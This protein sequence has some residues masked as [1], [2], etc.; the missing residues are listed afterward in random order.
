MKEELIKLQ[1]EIE[2][3]ISSAGS[4]ADIEAIDVK[5]FSRKGPLNAIIKQI[6]DLPD[7][8]KREFGP[9]VNAIKASLQATLDEAKKMFVPLKS[10]GDPTI[11]GKEFRV[12]HLNPITLMERE[13]VN[14]FASLGFSVF[15]GPELDSDYYNFE[16]LNIPADHPARD[17]Q[18]TFYVEQEDGSLDVLMRTQTSNLQVRAMRKFGAPLRVVMPGRVFR[19]EA[20]DARHEHT[21]YQFEG[22]MV[23]PGINFS[24]L[25]SI[26]E[27]V[28]KKLYGPETKIRMRPKFYPFVEPGSN[29]EYTCFLCSG[30]GCRVCKNTGWLEIVGCG[31]IHPKVLEA[32][33]ID[34]KK[35][36]GF[37]FGFGLSRLAMLK[38][39]IDEVRLMTG[40]DLR[41]LE[42]F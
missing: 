8:K 27:V 30:K 14:I 28:G 5:Y 16:S 11:P 35:Y 18:D 29:G 39:N 3:S 31:L 17:M 37:A 23:A 24:H 42:Q 38:Y 33:G 4:L 32:G 34:P 6:K 20:T 9:F 41:F 36:S 25:K 12:G 15:D 40:N 22:V 1:K 19:N 10:G 21:F 7:D 13:L 2:A 26:F